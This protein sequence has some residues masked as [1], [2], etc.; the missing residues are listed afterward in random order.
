MTR[1]KITNNKYLSI[2]RPHQWLKNL[3]LLFPP[4][5]GGKILQTASLMKIVPSLLSFC[6]AASCCYI[7]NDIIDR[8]LDQR[9]PTKKDRAIARGDMHVVFAYVFAACLYVAAMLLS[10]SVSSRFEGFLIL[11]LFISFLYTIYF[12]NIVIADIFF[13]SF[14]FL[15][16]VS[17]GGEAFRIPITNWLLLTVFMVAL[18]LAAGKRLGELVALGDDALIHRTSLLHYS[19]SFLEGI[20]WFTGSAAIV[21][22]SLYTIGNKSEMVYTVPIAAFGLL[23]YIFIVKEGKGDPTEALLK[24]KQILITGIFW[25]LMIGIIIYK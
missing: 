10:S 20:L 22:Y 21:T 2:L 25:A 8:N 3:L 1:L 4:F 11:Y 9:H 23:R 5:F 18:F 12:K 6:L 17:A 19:Q 14:G 15:I 24:D 13:I 16:R 7:I